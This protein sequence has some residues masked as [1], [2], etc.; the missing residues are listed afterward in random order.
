MTAEEDRTRPRKPI[1]RVLAGET[2]SP[3]PYWLMRQAGR[4]LPEYR[5]LRQRSSSFLEFCLTPDRAAEATLQPIRRFGMNAAILFSDI[6]VIPH[7]LGRSVA[8]CEG[9][10]PMLEPL[11]RREEVEALARGAVEER[12]GPVYE[13]VRRVSTLLPAETALL[14]FAGGPWTVAT[15]MVEGG[16]SRDFAAVKR[17]ALSDAE[18]FDRLID[19]L[20]EATI[21][22]LVAQLEAG[23]DAVQI[24]ESWAG[25]LDP[26]AFRRFVIEPTRRVVAGV[27]ARQMQAPIIGFPRG[28]GLMYRDYVTETGVTAV[29]LDSA[30]PCA[31]A[32]KTLQSLVPVQGNLDPLRLA[33]GGRILEN[34]VGEI[35]AALRDGPFIFNLGHGVVP[36]TP[37]EHVMRLAE[38]LRRI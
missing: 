9:E 8:F 26:A 32:R 21:A 15:Y 1:L 31:V 27:R 37:V 20:V 22:H 3:L 10:G 23:A 33:V 18:G 11:R 29:S 30:V 34:G 6:L 13:T 5:E 38:L 2:L 24:F 36:D 17:W 28:A 12:L 14:G 4:Y 19:V 25:V 7:A 35:V 16:T